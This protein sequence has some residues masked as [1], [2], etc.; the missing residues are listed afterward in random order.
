M[1]RVFS[2]VC[3]FLTGDSVPA[4][5]ELYGL[6]VF[7]G[8][9]SS[10]ANAGKLVTLDRYSDIRG[11]IGA[12]PLARQLEDYFAC[13]GQESRALAF[14]GAADTPGTA[15]TVSKTGTGA[16][17]VTV[18]GTP[19]D[20]FSCR[21]KVITGGAPG[22][23]VV[24]FS[25]DG[26]LNYGTSLTTPASG[27]LDVGST[28]MK[29]AFTGTFVAGDE[30]SW[31]STA[32][33][34]TTAHVLD[35]MNLAL[36]NYRGRFEFFVV[37][38]STTAPF[39]TSVSTLL[40]TELARH[41]PVFAIL[42]AGGVDATTKDTDV[43][44][45]VTAASG[46]S[47][48]FVMLVALQT[49]MANALGE[50]MVRVPVG[51][52]AGILSKG[53]VS[54]SVGVL[55]DDFGKIQPALALNPSCLTEGDLVLLDGAG[56]TVP[57][58]YDGYPELFFNNGNILSPPG[59]PYDDVEKVRVAGKLMRLCRVAALRSLHLDAATSQSYAFGG[60]AGLAYLEEE[61][62]R[63]ARVML[64]AG[65]L[66]GFEPKVLSTP[67]DV[68]QTKTVQVRLAYSTNPKM[69]KINLTFDLVSPD[70]FEQ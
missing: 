54:D 16:G 57:R 31:S 35:A 49:V 70:D 20:A 6:P 50:V 25:V 40:Q 8:V 36:S 11:R 33:A 60:A 13:G 61:L 39:W 52:L 12:G 66:Y 56:Y 9:G 44:A 29:A 26:G 59:D 48:R 47:S 42:D 21:V 7:I 34:M 69:K 53:K 28:G 55:N 62:R 30:Y 65:E 46:F 10:A 37:V 19:S 4:L 18:S 51:A 23:A 64:V 63:A 45:K 58:W 14:V 68:Y 24:Q 38:G 17:T 5:G 27:T 1:T 43:A 15:G 41:N 3:E 67:E 22:T 2:N 32:P